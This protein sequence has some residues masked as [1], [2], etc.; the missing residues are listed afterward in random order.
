MLTRLLM[1]NLVSQRIA[2]A[3]ENWVLFS[4]LYAIDCAK[5]P[6]SVVWAKELDAAIGS[7]S[8]VKVDSI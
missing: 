8:V 2:L 6:L 1:M 3:L 4:V 5:L 7:W